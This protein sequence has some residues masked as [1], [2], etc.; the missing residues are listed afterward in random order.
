M[1]NHI[2]ELIGLDH[3]VLRVR[4]PKRMLEF[5]TQVLGCAL[6]RERA[7]LGLYQLRAG[8]QLID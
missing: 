5:Y 6:E 2:F 7:E 8:R 3:L 1:T 4:H